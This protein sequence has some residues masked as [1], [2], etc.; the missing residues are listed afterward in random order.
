MLLK[1]ILPNST[2][3]NI[4]NIYLPPYTSLKKRNIQDSVA[5]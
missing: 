4:I 5:T 2:R 3:I 1:L